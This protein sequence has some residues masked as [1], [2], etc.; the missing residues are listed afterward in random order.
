MV[1]SE[2]TSLCA[3]RRGGLGKVRTQRRAGLPPRPLLD[4]PAPP[5]LSLGPVSSHPA[6]LPP[7]LGPPG[8]LD[9]GLA[10]QHSS[11]GMGSGICII[12]QS[13]QTP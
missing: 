10:L 11:P 3:E 5:S 9:P 13:G 6:L 8:L 4:G 2:L 1:S 12:L 7:G